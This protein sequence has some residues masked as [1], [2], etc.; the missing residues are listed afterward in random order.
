MTRNILL[1]DRLAQLMMMLI[2]MTGDAA[3]KRW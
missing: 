3:A 2:L 1:N